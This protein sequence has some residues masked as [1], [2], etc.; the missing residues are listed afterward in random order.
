[1][2]SLAL[3]A[4]PQ[5]AGGCQKSVR[6]IISVL[7]QQPWQELVSR[8]HG[9]E[10]KHGYATCGN[11]RSEVR[12]NCGGP[13]AQRDVEEASKFGSHGCMWNSSMQVDVV[14]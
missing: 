10:P 11:R 3:P 9:W 1:M 7:V 5:L 8:A 12:G 13:A 2:S 6:A 14:T 4:G